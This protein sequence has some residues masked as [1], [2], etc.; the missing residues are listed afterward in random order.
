MIDLDI[1]EIIRV[2]QDKTTDVTYYLNKTTG[3]VVYVDENIASEL[4]EEYDAV[5]T[6]V[7]EWDNDIEDDD[8]YHD[9][10]F[11]DDDDDIDEKELIKQIRYTNQENFEP[12]PVLIFSEIKNIFLEFVKTLDKKEK[13]IFKNYEM[14]SIT[15]YELLEDLIRN[16]L[17]EK[18]KWEE[19]LESYLKNQVITWLKYLDLK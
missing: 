4:E 18:V 6:A 2:M 7:E 3:E 16:V 11:S 13:E 14:D 17:A 1:D 19:F 9:K 12:I 10:I 5:D 8:T 15:S